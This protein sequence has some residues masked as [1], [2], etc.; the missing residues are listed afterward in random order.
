TLAM[1]GF[2]ARPLLFASIDPEV[3]AARGV[4]VKALS[5]L[6]LLLLAVATAEA[7]QIT[8][9]LL[10]FALLVLPAATAETLTARP[11]L[12]LALSVALALFVTWFGLALSYYNDYPIGFH[13]TS[14]AFGVYV[15][16]HVWRVVSRAGLMRL[17]PR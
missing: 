7:S 17:Q 4:P 13:I 12:S 11:A 6:F 16:S 15:L 10:V 2:V 5:L 9:A 14:L 8:G 1:L 3:A